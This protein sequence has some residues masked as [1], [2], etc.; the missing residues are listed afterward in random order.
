MAYPIHTRLEWEEKTSRLT[1]FFRLI[2]A[3][4]HSFVFAFWGIA[5][6]WSVAIMA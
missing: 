5:S 1:T 4:E 6:G 2:L 3:V